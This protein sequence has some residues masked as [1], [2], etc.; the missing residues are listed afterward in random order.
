VVE[1]NSPAH[2][3]VSCAKKGDRTVGESIAKNGPL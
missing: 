2:L 3:I 1:L